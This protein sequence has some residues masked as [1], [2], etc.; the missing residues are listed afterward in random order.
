LLSL[1]FASGSND[2]NLG[3]ELF[4]GA[5]FLPEPSF[6]DGAGSFRCLNIVLLRSFASLTNSFLSLC[7]WTANDELVSRAY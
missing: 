4:F 7:A 6:S 3:S 2:F 1:L 5:L